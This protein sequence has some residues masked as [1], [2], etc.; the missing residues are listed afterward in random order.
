VLD[1][2][3]FLWFVAALAGAFVVA[4][5]VDGGRSWAALAGGPVAQLSGVLIV[6]GLTAADVVLVAFA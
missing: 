3:V 1:L 2:G 6:V 4:A 5:R